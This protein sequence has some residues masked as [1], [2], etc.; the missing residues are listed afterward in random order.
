[1][2]QR[3]LLMMTLMVLFLRNVLIIQR[4]SMSIFIKFSR[5]LNFLLAAFVFR[6]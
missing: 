5:M 1:M 2:R 6:I 3:T 4:V